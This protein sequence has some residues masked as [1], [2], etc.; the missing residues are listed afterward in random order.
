[1]PFSEPEM[2][3]ADAAAEFLL[4][5]QGGETYRR[6]AEHLALAWKRL[7]VAPAAPA[8]DEA[9]FPAAAD[10]PPPPADGPRTPPTPRPRSSRVS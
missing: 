1:M 8:D 2:N 5:R 9:A 3:Y 10:L 7:R 4:S 6:A